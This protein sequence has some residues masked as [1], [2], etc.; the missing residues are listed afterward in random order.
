MYYYYFIDNSIGLHV[1]GR[2]YPGTFAAYSSFSEHMT[3]R[4]VQ[5]LDDPSAASYLVYSSEVAGAFV[6]ILSYND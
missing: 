1:S 4:Q 6:S 2:V 5:E 3:E